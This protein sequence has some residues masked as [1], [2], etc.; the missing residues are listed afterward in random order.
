[1]SSLTTSPAWMS[2]QEH[3]KIM[4][5]Q[6]MRM[7]FHED[8]DRFRKFSLSAGPL[9]LDY[10]KNRITE[11]TVSLLLDLARQCHVSE[12]VNRMFKGEKINFTEHRAVLH[13][14][15]RN[16]STETL[17]VDG[18][19][20]REQVHH[21]LSQMKRFTES[22]R[23]GQWKGYTGETITDVV[24]IGI[25]GSDLG[26]A[27]AARALE[28]DCTVPRAHFVSNVDGAHLAR[29]LKHLNP[30]RTLFVVAS[31]TFTT[32]ETLM[33]ARSAR[34]WFLSQARYEKFIPLHFV[35]LS[36][37]QREVS[38]FGISPDHMF[39]F[40]DWVGGRYSLWSSIG[41]SLALTLGMDK[42]SEM[43]LG[44]F[45]I[46][47]HFQTA[48]LEKNMPVILA[49]LGVWYINFFNAQT[50]AILPYDQGMS[51]FV[52]YL[53]QMTMESNG[54]SV[55]REGLPVDYATGS[56]L[57]GGVGTN[58][59]HAYF[60]LLHQGTP[61]IPAD[62]IAPMH[63]RTPLGNHHKI[64]LSNFLA[65]T[66]ALM[67]GKSRSEAQAELISSGLE[68]SALQA[69]LPHKCFAGN[70]PSNSLLIDQLNPRSLGALVALYEHKTFVQSL[71]WDINAFDQW[72]VELGK[73]L[74]QGIQAEWDQRPEI[75]N[76]DASTN[77]LLEMIR[78]T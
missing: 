6:H 3:Q 74:A 24:N 2:L 67:R 59:Q 32:Q 56:I 26:P 44:A 77:G 63:S 69:L 42:F 62:F 4:S 34:E 60:Q 66:E 38:A 11:K 10:S 64:L 23:S 53:Q 5:E 17:L 40:W 46:D 54:K 70:R 73:Q 47:E 50:H 22:V 71:I 48:P 16:P 25:G 15:L 7:M 51:D 61:L 27:M 72:G 43:L 55:T 29:T 18:V 12:W 8:P 30:A 13:T 75:S 14:A 78:K 37:N 65:Q 68:K 58:G 31:K 20:V 33:N 35:A 9:F 19:N 36:T 52:N 49:L 21:V 45:E 57:W 1:M 76:H 39:E 28:E 41:L